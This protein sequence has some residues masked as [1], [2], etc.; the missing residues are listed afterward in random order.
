VEALLLLP[1]IWF[2]DTNVLT[3]WVLGRGTIL[4]FLCEQF[5]LHEDFFHVYMERYKTAIEFI[6]TV[7]GQKSAGLEDEFYVSSLATNELFSA[8]RDETRSILFFKQGIPLSRWRDARNVPDI[9]E[10]CVEALYQRTLQSFDAIFEHHGIVIIPEI[11]PW[12]NDNYWSIYASIL[13]LIRQ[14]RTQDA[15]LLTTAILNRADYFVTLDTP[16]ISSSKAMMQ[17]TYDM[18]LINPTEALQLL[19]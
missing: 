1:D 2:I 11:S 17:A 12:D 15:T 6:D 18:H 7:L 10:K 5:K 9:P 14:S 3:H 4:S 13:F 16:L 8:I 19:R